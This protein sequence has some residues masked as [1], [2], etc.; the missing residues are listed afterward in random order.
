MWGHVAFEGL[1]EKA[2]DR[3]LPMML[4]Q[5]TSII[6]LIIAYHPPDTIFAMAEQAFTGLA[7]LFPTVIAALY[8]RQLNSTS[9]II[10]IV[11]GEAAVVGFQSGI[12]PESLTFGFLP[13][14]SIVALSTLIILI[15]VSKNLEFCLLFIPVF[16]PL[17]HLVNFLLL[18]S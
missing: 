3:I 14:V 18:R 12:I 8:C 15:G 6:G 1:E 17:F 5:Y 11:V 9:C 13:V 2:S 4:T 10:S 7:V 16:S